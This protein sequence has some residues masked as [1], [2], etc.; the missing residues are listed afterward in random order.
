MT[1]NGH[2][3]NF[4]S[5]SPVAAINTKLLRNS[6]TS[7]YACNLTGTVSVNV[8]FGGRTWSINPVDMNLG[9]LGDDPANCRVSIF[10]LP[11]PSNG[12]LGWIFGVPFLRNVYSVFKLNPAEIGFAELS[13][14][15]GGSS[16]PQTST[17]SA[18]P[19]DT[20]GTPSRTPSP[21]PHPR[22]QIKAGIVAGLIIGAII[23]LG[24]LLGV[25][26]YVKRRGRR[27]EPQDPLDPDSDSD[28]SSI[29]PF[30]PHLSGSA[31]ISPAHRKT[32]PAPMNPFARLKQEQSDVLRGL[33]RMQQTSSAENVRD[34]TVRTSRGLALRVDNTESER[35][36]AESSET[37][38]PLIIDTHV[39]TIPVVRRELATL[40]EQVR[41]LEYLTSWRLR[42]GSS[43]DLIRD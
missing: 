43:S 19:T 5:S 15:A 2:G 13:E 28:G 1:I 38:P 8:S 32:P 16:Q 37:T 33:E 20:P 10:G 24:L 36:T 17:S 22:S 18:T 21:S 11:P 12:S 42:L 23:V 14:I 34:H 3:V 9:P 4:S 35:G 31:A 29:T 26:F 40:R 39:P 6:R 41:R 30:I 27:R 7:R 25:T